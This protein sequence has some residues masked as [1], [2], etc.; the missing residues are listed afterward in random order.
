MPIE[1]Q[2]Q[3]VGFFQFQRDGSGISGFETGGEFHQLLAHGI[4]LGPA[5][6]RRHAIFRGDR[7]AVMPFQSVAQREGVG[8]LVIADL[9]IGHLR[10]DLETGI[11]RQQ[12]VEHHVAMVTGDVGGGETGIDDAQVGMHDR[13]DGFAR[14]KRRWRGQAAESAAAESA[15]A[16]AGYFQRRC[17]TFDISR[18]EPVNQRSSVWRV[19]RPSK[20]RPFQFQGVERCTVPR[21]ASSVATR[22]RTASIRARLTP[23]AVSLLPRH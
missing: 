17:E 20:Q 15:E 3:A 7:R 2:H 16:M 5:L 18:H 12:R 9:P 10:L 6:Q 13:G 4:R 23:A 14:R 8:E 11:G 19:W 21:G 22:C 1:L